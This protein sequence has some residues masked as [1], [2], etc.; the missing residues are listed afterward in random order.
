MTEF[1]VE[2]EPIPQGSMKAFVRGR[3]AV[4]VSD[5]PRL[6]EWRATIAAN[7]PALMLEGAVRLDVG[8][9]MPKPKSVKRLLPHVRPDLDKLIRALLDGLTG[10]CFKDDSQVVF[11]STLR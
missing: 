1:F 11:I 10:K 8:F 4:L 7:A 3:R 6:K 2:G 5:N 9:V